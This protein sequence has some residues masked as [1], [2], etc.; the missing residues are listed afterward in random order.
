MSDQN[1]IDC[2]GA[3]REVRRLMIDVSKL[4]LEV[5]SLVGQEGWELR[6]GSTAISGGSTSVNLP[7]NWL[8]FHVFRFYRNAEFPSTIPCVAVLLDAEDSKIRWHEPHVSALIM[9]YEAGSPLPEG[10]QLTACA[11]WHLYIP[12]RKDDGSLNVV[13]PRELWPTQTT[14][15]RMTSFVVP[16]MSIR[17][18]LTLKSKVV[19]PLSRALAEIRSPS[20]L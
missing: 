3:I 1:G 16:L 13:V 18:Q 11:N 10:W 2:L 19:E 14:A 6:V 12:G 5:D 20:V 4:L 8:P 17:D 15:K 7:R 9:E